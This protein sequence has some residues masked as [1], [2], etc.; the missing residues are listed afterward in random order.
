[1]KNIQKY[2]LDKEHSTKALDEVVACCAHGQ[3]PPYTYI[4]REH[5][6]ERRVI[7]E[8]RRVLAPA[9]KL[10]VV[11]SFTLSVY[12]LAYTPPSGKT[13]FHAGCHAQRPLPEGFP[14]S[15]CPG[16]VEQGVDCISKAYPSLRFPAPGVTHPMLAL[17]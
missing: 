2:T 7:F 4:Q 5:S 1:M 12:N 6:T 9:L 16:P 14:K 11:F 17:E 15:C 8:N 3:D 10:N 13:P